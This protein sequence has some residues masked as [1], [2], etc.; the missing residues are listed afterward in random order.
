MT[1]VTKMM[2][3]KRWILIF[4]FIT[5]KDALLC[6]LICNYRNVLFAIFLKMSLT[7]SDPSQE[8]KTVP[9]SKFSLQRA[10]PLIFLRKAPSKMHTRV[11]NITLNIF[12]IFLKR[13]SKSVFNF[14]T[15]L[16]HWH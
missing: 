1:F 4:S 8:S 9:F 16:W 7:Y 10:R 3:V 13:M 12:K 2:I 11:L 6:K 15:F 5:S 14:L